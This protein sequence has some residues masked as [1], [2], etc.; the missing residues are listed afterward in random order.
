MCDQTSHTVGSHFMA[1]SGLVSHEQF[2]QFIAIYFMSNDSYL[3]LLVFDH[4]PLSKIVFYLKLMQHKTLN[5][6]IHLPDVEKCNQM[7]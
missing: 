2:D 5:F 3:R 7:A 1:H 6:V 4:W